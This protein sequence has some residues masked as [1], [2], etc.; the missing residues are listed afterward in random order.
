MANIRR[1]NQLWYARGWY[2]FGK[3]SGLDRYEEQFFSDWLLVN[4]KSEESSVEP[5]VA[6]ERLQMVAVSGDRSSRLVPPMV[7]HEVAP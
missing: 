2:G 5:E 1:H 3:Q 4:Q 6:T 7:T